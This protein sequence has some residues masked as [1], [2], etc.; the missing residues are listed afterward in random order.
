[1][2]PWYWRSGD[3]TLVLAESDGTLVLAESDGTL[4]LAESDGTILCW[5]LVKIYLCGV[6][7]KQNKERS[8][9]HNF[10]CCQVAIVIKTKSAQNVR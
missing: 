7:A 2:V 8:I 6:I 3:G 4:V 1:M 5:I 10:E 9:Q